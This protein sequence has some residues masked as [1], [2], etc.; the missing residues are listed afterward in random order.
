MSDERIT[1]VREAHMIEILGNVSGLEEQVKAIHAEL[2]ETNKQQKEERGMVLDEL[3]ATGTIERNKL[4]E[5]AAK[6]VRDGVYGEIDGIKIEVNK[7]IIEFNRAAEELRSKKR[8]DFI[9]Y[10]FLSSLG[11][12][13]ATLFF[14]KIILKH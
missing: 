6:L 10:V 9:S 3:R 11:V 1:N 7:L 14:E 2:V 4:A 12:V 8:W 13:L 5:K